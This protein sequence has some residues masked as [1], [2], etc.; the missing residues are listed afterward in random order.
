MTKQVKENKL[1]CEFMGY[2]VNYN[3]ATF[4]DNLSLTEQWNNDKGTWVHTPKGQGLEWY[5][6]LHRKE[7]FQ[8]YTDFTYSKLNKK[9]LELGC[10]IKGDYYTLKE[11]QYNQNWNLLTEVMKKIELHPNSDKFGIVTLHG[12][13]RTTIQCYDNKQNGGQLLHTIDVLDEPYGIQPTYK[14]ILEYIKG[15]NNDR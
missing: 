13:G 1:I 2:S 15:Y 3:V 6:V 10:Y 7:F 5:R 9:D 8:L 11:L 14:A 4:D 12:L